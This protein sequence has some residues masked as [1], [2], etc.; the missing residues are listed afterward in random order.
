[1]KK[2]IKIDLY[3]NHFMITVYDRT[4]DQYIDN[5]INELTSYTYRYNYRTKRNERVPDRLYGVAKREEGV[6]RFTNRILKPIL[7]TMGQLGNLTSDEIELVKHTEEQGLPIDIKFKD[8]KFKARDYQEEYVEQ[9]LANKIDTLLVDLSVGLG[10]G[11][12]VTDKVRIP[13]GWKAIGSLKVGDKVMAVDGTY[14]TVTGVFPQGMRPIY[15]IKFKDG[16]SIKVDENHLWEISTREI[17]SSYK[18][19]EK[20]YEP[21]YGNNNRVKKRNGVIRTKTLYETFN[22]PVYEKRLKKNQSTIFIPLCQ[23]EKNKDKEFFIHPY[24]LGCILGDGSISNTTISLSISDL[25]VVERFRSFL[26]KDYILS[27]FRNEDN[28]YKFNLIPKEGD[29]R[30][31]KYRDELIRLK[32]MGRRAWEK[33]IP[34]EYL[35][36]SEEQRWELLR[37]LMD[38]DGWVEKSKGRNGL[39]HNPKTKKK[40]NGNIMFGTTSELLAYS[41]SQLV[42]SMGDICRQSTKI[43]HYTHKNQRKT[44]RIF[45]KLS[46]RSKTPRK[47]FTRVSKRLERLGEESQY[48][49]NLMLAIESITK[50]KKYEKTV[51]IMVEHPR[52]L[53]VMQDYI[54]THN[55]FI[56]M[57]AIS[58]IKK[59]TAI[60]ILPKYIDKW[61]EDIHKYTYTKP[62]R[63]YIVRGS[64]S[65]IWLM[66]HPEE[67]KKDY[68]FFIFSMRTI[69][70][71]LTEYI[72]VPMKDYHYLKY[73]V[74][75]QDLFKLLGIGVL[76]VDEVH[77]EFHNFYYSILYFTVDKV[78]ALSAT[79]VSDKNKMTDIH[80]TIFPD[81]KR[82]SNL[83]KLHK[84]VNL[85]VI[86]YYIDRGNKIRC[87]S[88]HG[89]SHIK[90]EQYVLSNSRLLKQM[91]TMYMKYVKRDF[92]D[93]RQSGDK[94]LVFCSTVDMCRHL[95]TVIDRHCNDNGLNLKV[96]TYVESDSYDDMLKLDIIVSTVISSGTAIDIPGLLTVIQTISIG[97]MVANIQAF[98]RLRRRKDG[99]ECIYDSIYCYDINKQ[100]G[101]QKRRIDSISD[102]CKSINYE[103]Y[104]PDLHQ[105]VLIR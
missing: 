38:T 43:P 75:P 62:D 11:S 91:D 80:A 85:N 32:L 101:L 9:L 57:N 76:L 72:D 96:G 88:N 79:L 102:K 40:Y 21:T 93:I 46:I 81:N 28:C 92:L 52:H 19:F 98:G 63:V 99:R 4:L 47:Y 87:E 51:C 77:Q 103:I 86:K 44:G 27:N 71:Y 70:N 73:P 30:I 53:Y 60:L 3:G 34:R 16:R 105:S 74:E 22:H 23:P 41:V 56:A 83:V 24:I 29:I 90:F 18:L 42:Y 10:K 5:Y 84:H 49:G 50:L 33:F 2:R 45:Y 48:S 100:R 8:N 94:L 104:M 82:I 25:G 78:I 15:E 14:T 12:L 59:K 37:G 64:D 89:Y 67:A 17:H 58:K 36:G 97:S 54:V 20:E 35:N 7:G 1:M 55:T 31:N 68:D 61:V 13:D 39:A 95:S 26:D 69:S 65:L 6:Y 66:E